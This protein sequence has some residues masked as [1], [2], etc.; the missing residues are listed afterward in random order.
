MA[1]QC[2]ASSFRLMMSE[3]R[4]LLDRKET[5]IGNSLVNSNGNKI[6]LSCQAFE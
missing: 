3:L 2:L 4:C 5:G 1:D 6:S